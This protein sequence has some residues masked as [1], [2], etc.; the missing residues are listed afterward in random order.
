MAGVEEA[1]LRATAIAAVEIMIEQGKGAFW[2]KEIGD[3]FWTLGKD[4]RYRSLER[5][6]TPDTCFY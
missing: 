1:E 6:A 2:A 3:F 5:H 4:T